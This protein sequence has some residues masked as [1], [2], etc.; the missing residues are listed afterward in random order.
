M[1]MLGSNADNDAA[2]GDGASGIGGISGIAGMAE[3]PKAPNPE[4]SADSGDGDTSE[5]LYTHVRMLEL[6]VHHS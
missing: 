3:F 2:E 5:V 6:A 4:T 1:I